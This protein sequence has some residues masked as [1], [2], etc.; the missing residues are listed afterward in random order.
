M[1]MEKER[2]L[3]AEY[4]RK[5]STSG[6]SRGTA[7]NISIFDPET[8]YMAISPSGL[9]Y[10]ETE[11]KDVVVCDLDGKV[12]DGDRKPSSEY[13]LHAGFYKDRGGENCRAIVHTHSDYATTLACMGEPLRAVHY[14]IATLGTHEI[15]L[16]GYT[17]FGTPKLAE[18]AV[19]AANEGRAVLLANHGLVTWAADVAKAF[20]QAGNLESLAKTQWQCM[21]AG[22]MN[23]LTKEQIDDV[24]V[25]F[26]TYGQKKSNTNS[27]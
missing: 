7:G 25:R 13:G 12:V 16:C 27:Y 1:L 21:A 24:L 2:E 17:T 23:V 15:P 22:K 6:L 5:M 9:G 18:M 14:V 26:Q 3:V 20:N 11:A 10:F 8:G 19:A 4:G